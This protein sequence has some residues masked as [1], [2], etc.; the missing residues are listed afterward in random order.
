[1][2]VSS[3]MQL[4]GFRIII[5]LYLPITGYRVLNIKWQWYVDFL[6]AF[7]CINIIRPQNSDQYYICKLFVG[8]IKIKKKLMAISNDWHLRWNEK[9]NIPE[10]SISFRITCIFCTALERGN[11][12]DRVLQK[13]VLSSFRR[14]WMD[15]KTSSRRRF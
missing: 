9:Y 11:R 7:S 8:D 14:T 4:R 10:N 5:Q 3:D 12:H 6:F 15:P 1:M 13:I 2:K